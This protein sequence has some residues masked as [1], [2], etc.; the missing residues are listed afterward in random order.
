MIGTFVIL[1]LEFMESLVAGC[2]HR[3]RGSASI[4]DRG[5]AGI[6]GRGSA[7]IGAGAE[8]AAAAHV[9]AL[10]RRVLGAVVLDAKPV[11][12]LVEAAEALVVA[13]GGALEVASGA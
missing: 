12:L 11:V 7:R 3:G 6:R 13:V 9:V 10:G 8:P 4:R 1:V 5:S 2:Q